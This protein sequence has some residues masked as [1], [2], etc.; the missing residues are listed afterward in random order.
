MAN[1]WHIDWIGKLLLKAAYQK[2]DSKVSEFSTANT[3]LAKQWH[4]IMKVLWVQQCGDS[5]CR[6]VQ[7]GLDCYVLK[8]NCRLISKEIHTMWKLITNGIDFT[9]PSPLITGPN[10]WL[11]TKINYYL[12]KHL[13][14][15]FSFQ[16]RNTLVIVVLDAMVTLITWLPHTTINAITT[17]YLLNTQIN[18]TDDQVATI[19]TLYRI[20]ELCCC[21]LLTN[22]FT[23]PIIYFCF[24]RQ[25]RVSQFSNDWKIW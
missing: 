17:H 8:E 21:I 6:I 14:L 5:M 2:R 7:D 19:I 20:K 13:F 9:G 1:K 12:V 16:I 15:W 18:F 11:W 22:C 25:F 10:Q 24:N 3:L 4:G 23:S